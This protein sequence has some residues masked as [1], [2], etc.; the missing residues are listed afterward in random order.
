MFLKGMLGLG[1]N[2][3]QRAIVRELGPLSLVTSW[4]QLYVDLPVQCV[5]PHTSLR[6]QQKN[7]ARGDL[8]WYG[9]PRR[10]Q[11]ISFGY[12][13]EGTILQSLLDCLNIQRTKLIFDGPPVAKLDCRPYILM[14]PATLRHEWRADARNPLPEYLC[15][16]AD[17]LKEHFQIISVADLQPPFEW[18]VG[19]LP[20]AHETYHH[21]EL[22]LEDLL[23]LVAGAAGVVGGVGWLAPA[24]VAYKVPMLLIYG[25]WGHANGPQRILDPR[26]DTSLLVQAMPDAY[27]PCNDRA[28]NCARTISNF[29]EHLANFIQLTQ[30]KQTSV[31]S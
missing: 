31:A 14:R 22:R 3:Y 11:A 4:P 30:S 12:G 10:E 25:G 29:G 21:G 5:R 2:I 23:A 15:Q 27:C 1:D 26:M 7:A 17:A 24:A 16:A 6:T 19:D 9:A 13:G 28:H 8:S 20:F 18:H